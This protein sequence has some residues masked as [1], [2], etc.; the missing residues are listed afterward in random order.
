MPNVVNVAFMAARDWLL[1]GNTVLRIGAV[2][3]F[4]G[5][6]F[7]LRYA[8]EG[9]VVPIETRYA[10]VA[11]SAIALLGLGWWLRH[12]RQPSR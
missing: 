4:L 6:A 1:G 5:L 10:G 2:V 11:G 7:L 8:T 12:R 3:L 9:V